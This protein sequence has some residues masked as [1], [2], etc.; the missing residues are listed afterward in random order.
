MIDNDGQIIIKFIDKI[1]SP[2]S[3][4]STEVRGEGFVS[5]TKKDRRENFK[6]KEKR[7]SID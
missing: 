6:Q 2:F 4:G 3:K 7:L 1:I 5:F